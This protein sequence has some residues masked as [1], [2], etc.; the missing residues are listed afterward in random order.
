MAT[1]AN[2][3]LLDW[4]GIALAVIMGAV[5]ALFGS[6]AFLALL[7]VFL[8]AAV[9]G[10][11]WLST[12]NDISSRWSETRP[13]SF[14]SLENAKQAPWLPSPGGILYSDD[15][16][17]FY[18][19][20]FKNPN[21]EWCY[22]LGFEPALMTP[23]NLAIFR[24]IQENYRAFTSFRPWV[25]KMTPKEPGLF[26]PHGECARERPQRRPAHGEAHDGP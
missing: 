4:A 17:M 5:V 18:Q 21:A 15:M 9:A 8:V 11:L 22:V 13:K 14:I 19:V 24:N 12:T 7:L 3:A 16:S 6:S 10:I 26:Q 2:V 20:F 23:E 25:R 1:K